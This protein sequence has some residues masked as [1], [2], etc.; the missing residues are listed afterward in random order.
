MAVTASTVLTPA[1]PY[2]AGI[3]FPTQ[4]MSADGAITIPCGIVVITKSSACAMTLAAP[5]YD[6]Q[7]LMITA[8]TAHAHT[9]DLA[10]TGING[11]NADVG[12]FTSAVA[13]YVCIVSYGGNWCQV[14]NLNVSWA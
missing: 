11:G 14:S 12:T 4:V 7:Y 1:L 3:Q 6:G 10:T 9:L 5:A 13:N 8:N 2:P